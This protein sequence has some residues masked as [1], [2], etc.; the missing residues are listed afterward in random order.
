MHCA[1]HADARTS[2]LPLPSLVHHPFPL[3]LPLLTLSLSLAPW[4]P[5][6]FS[7]LFF[8]P[9][10]ASASPTPSFTAFSPRLPPSVL[11]S[12]QPFFLLLLLSL[13]LSVCLFV[14][15]HSSLVASRRFLSR[16]FLDRRQLLSL[17][18][19]RSISVVTSLSLFFSLCVTHAVFPLSHHQCELEAPFSSFAA[20]HTRGIVI[21]AALSSTFVFAFDGRAGSARSAELTRAPARFFDTLLPSARGGALNDSFR[22]DNRSFLFLFSSLFF[23]FYLARMVVDSR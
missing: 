13:S 14:C 20:Q 22:V 2:P 23:L 21:V 19:S 1:V 12:P 10:R 17:S 5:I 6:F 18:P 9:S 11:F 3:F 4:S 16:S 8:P 7:T 15:M